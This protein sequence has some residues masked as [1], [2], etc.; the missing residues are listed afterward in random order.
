MKKTSSRGITNQRFLSDLKNK[1]SLGKMIDIV[2]ADPRLVFHLRENYINIYYKSGNIAKI[3]SAN[4]VSIDKNYFIDSESKNYVRSKDKQTEND[5]IKKANLQKQRK[6]TEQLFKDRKYK[7]YFSKMIQVMENYWHYYEKDK[8]EDEGDVQQQLCLQNQYESIN[9]DFIILDLE[10]E[11][12]TLSDF[13][14]TGRSPFHY[15]DKGFPLKINKKN[16]KPKLKE[17]PRFDIVAINKKSGQLCII[18]LKKGEKALLGISGMHDHV[19]SFLYTIKTSTKSEQSFIKEMEGILDQKKELGLI[20]RDVHITNDSVLF[21]FAY[22][23]SSKN[24]EEQDKEKSTVQ[25]LL[26]SELKGVNIASYKVIYLQPNQYT[27]IL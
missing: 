24:K 14:Y 25:S 8:N 7:E 13:K 20:P 26:N 2:K 1:E 12:S 5:R 11:V 15:D 18:E 22:S 21:I 17:K 3:T 9:S 4:S 16:K 10:Y 27:L 23:F 19:D 6:E